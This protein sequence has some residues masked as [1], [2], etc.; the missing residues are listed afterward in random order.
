MADADNRR[1]FAGT[2]VTPPS[3]QPL[4]LREGWGSE[5]AS[6]RPSRLLQHTATNEADVGTVGAALGAVALVLI[7]AAV[8]VVAFAF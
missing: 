4:Q 8:V 6:E 5:G 7:A 2:A 3:A 1:F